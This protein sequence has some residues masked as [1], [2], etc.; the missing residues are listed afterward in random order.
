MEIFSFKQLNKII[1]NEIAVQIDNLMKLSPE[2]LYEPIGY[3]LLMGGKRLRPM[4]LLIGF[5][6]F[7]D[8][9]EEAL[10]AAMAVEIF[11]NFTLLHDDIMDKAELRRNMKTV[12]V[13]FNQNKAILSGDA[14]SFLSYHYLLHCKSLSI[15]KILELF[16]KTAIEVCEGQ[17]LDMDFETRDDVTESEYI[18]MIRL[19][20]AVLLGCSLKM[21]ALLA[22]ADDRMAGQLYEYGL[23]LGLAFQLQDD[24]LD[25]YGEQNLFGKK[26]GGDI[27]S[28]KKTYLLIK[29]LEVANAEQKNKLYFWLN[30]VSFNPEEKITSVKS[31]LN[32]LRINDLTSNKIF[33][34]FNYASSI[35]EMLE[36]TEKQKGRLKLLSNNMI[37]RNH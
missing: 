11:H 10:P 12:H 9:M 7:S 32:E 26:I 36:L 34:Y 1:E 4:M 24:F 27:V 29:A 17:Q 2:G 14:M 3:S 22:G 33:E 15:S 35:L 28:N 5:N 8:K 20:T 23:N 19:K 25:T 18:R 31:L 37:Q 6:L 30:K 21:G 16:T 13:R